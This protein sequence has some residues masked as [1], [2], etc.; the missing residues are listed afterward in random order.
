MGI[1]S[2]S[3]T[4]EATGRVHELLL[5]LAKFGESVSIEA[6]SEKARREL[7][8]INLALT[9]DYPLAHDHCSQLIKDCIR[10]VRT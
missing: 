6:K 3:L 8:Q 5:C 1:L 7:S 4:P 2:F 10:L 9:A